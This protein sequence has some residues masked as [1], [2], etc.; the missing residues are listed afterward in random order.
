MHPLHAIL[1]IDKKDNL[2]GGLEL[3][4]ASTLQYLGAQI[5][6]WQLGLEWPL[7]FLLLDDNGGHYFAICR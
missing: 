6:R 5:A 7:G 2:Q 1:D 4:E 3:R